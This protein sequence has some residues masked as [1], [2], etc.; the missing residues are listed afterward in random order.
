MKTLSAAILTEINKLEGTEPILIVGIEWVE[1]GV[2]YYSDVDLPGIVGK[3]ITIGDI[4]AVVVD[5]TTSNTLD[6]TLD[7]IDGELKNITDSVNI[8]KVNC[9]I[10]Q[11]FGALSDT[12]DKFEIF[13]GQISTPFTW[14]DKDRTISFSVVSEI[15]SY[16]VGFSPEEGQLT[17]V[18]D[19]YIGKPWPLCF[20]SVVHV[21]AQKV[22]QT[23]EGV[24]LQDMCIADELTTAKK[25]NITFAYNEQLFLMNFWMQVVRGTNSICRI[26]SVVLADYI[27]CI[28]T[29]RLFI[30]ELNRI[31]TELDNQKQ[32]QKEGF[33][34]ARANVFNLEAQLEL[35]AVLVHLNAVRKENLER[36]AQLVE[37]KYNTQKEAYNKAI[38][39]Y[40]NANVLMDEYIGVNDQICREDECTVDSIQINNGENF[41]QGQEITILIKD[42]RFTGIFTGNTFVFS[43]GNVPKAKYTNVPIASW[44]LDE[45]CGAPDDETNGVAV[46]YLANDPPENLD[47]M[48]LLVKKRG[49]LDGWRHIIKVVRQ[50]GNKVIYELVGWGGSGS[51]GGRGSET[52][53]PSAQSID[54]VIGSLLQTPFIPT[55]FGVLPVDLF[56][57]EWAVSNWNTPEGV[58]V[59]NIIQN[60]PFGVNPREL[61]VITKLVFFAEREALGQDLILLEPSP[62]SFYT[63]VGEDVESIQEASPV[64][65]KHWLEDY[66]IPPEEIPESTTY[67]IDTGASVRLEADDNIIYIANILPSTIH[68]VY[69]YRTLKTGQRVLSAVPSSY[70]TAYEN[71]NLGTINVT[72]FK[73]PIS[74]PNLAG[75]N[76]EDDVYI[77]LT[78][79][80]GPN[81]C[82]IIEHLIDT[83]TD[84]GSANASNFA[85]IK[86]KFVDGSD[87]L[88]PANFALFDRPNVLDEI[89]RI[90]FEA[91][92]A[93]YRVGSEFFL[94]YLSEEPT[95]DVTF[96]EDD[97]DNDDNIRIVYPSTDGLVTRLVAIWHPNYLPLENGKKQDQLIYRHNYKLYGMQSEDIEFHIYNDRQS[98]EKSATFWMIR[99]ANTW[100]RVEFKAFL[101]DLKLDLFDTI[102]FN[103]SR[104]YIAN[105]AVKGVLLKATYDPNDNSILMEVELPVKSGEME[106]YKWY[107]PA[108]QGENDPFPLPIE[109]EKGYAGGFG[110]GSGVTGTI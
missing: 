9:T 57:G 26:A 24:T 69:A 27:Q 2:V 7:D 43:S 67:T 104:N 50:D 89:S 91:R 28:I 14:N 34:D 20:G 108:Q 73:F 32:R 15:E 56:N 58:A 81:V 36:E 64:I 78:S 6:L 59:L 39:A 16:E 105:S 86:A 3:I 76:W 97:I 90:A 83:Y 95:E 1:G 82:D 4:E 100:K 84:G 38:E 66:N 11:F 10:Y 53:Q 109:I 17:F 41:P 77:T 99:K 94:K 52:G 68:A 74:L 72:A 25:E 48:F 40:N 62:S 49:G 31:L 47:G 79:S 12:D 110:P 42:V 23:L 46:I 93:I 55:P 75:Q 88:Y 61:E 71:A 37:F 13:R 98:V 54:A 60:I 106:T 107:W 51:G 19:D 18:N 101:K 5:N 45:T 21:P 65:L 87:E 63:I 70:Y 44:A 33:A 103:F 35:F 29:E 30:I 85:A 102:K 92:C 22:S 80:V 96:T 8:H